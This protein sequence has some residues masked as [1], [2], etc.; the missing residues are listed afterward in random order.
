VL[1]GPQG[2]TLERFAFPSK[3]SNYF[4][5]T[6]LTHDKY[7]VIVANTDRNMGDSIICPRREVEFR[8]PYVGLEIVC[9][10]VHSQPGSDTVISRPWL[11]WTIATMSLISWVVIFNYRTLF[12]IVQTSFKTTSKKQRRGN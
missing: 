6:N 11:A 2:Q 3:L 12:S 9:E 7:T 1:L 5:F 10:T 4:Y 8:D